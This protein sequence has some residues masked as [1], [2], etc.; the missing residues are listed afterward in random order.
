MAGSRS[1]RHSLDIGTLTWSCYYVAST[2]FTCLRGMLVLEGVAGAGGESGHVKRWPKKVFRTDNVIK[3]HSKTHQMLHKS[4]NKA[5]S[6]IS[7]GLQ[8]GVRMFRARGRLFAAGLLGIGC[9]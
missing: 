8:I 5:S 2:L 9:V 3:V 7:W 4:L 1:S 6:A